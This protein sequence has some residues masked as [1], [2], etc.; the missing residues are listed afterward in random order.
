MFCKDHEFSILLF[1]NVENKNFD[2]SNNK[3]DPLY[4]F[5][6]EF[7]FTSFMLQT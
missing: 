6:F 4:L 2:S 1:H 5:L 3:P 7:Q